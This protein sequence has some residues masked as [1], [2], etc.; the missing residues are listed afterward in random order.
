MV[1]V[2]VLC[3][4]LFLLLLALF[5]MVTC[6]HRKGCHHCKEESESGIYTTICLDDEEL[7]EFMD[8]EFD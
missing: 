3:S 6:Y 4:V 2:L 1:E 8:R 7:E 5:G